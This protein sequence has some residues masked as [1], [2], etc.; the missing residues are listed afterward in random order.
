MN[1]PTAA[2]PRLPRQVFFIIGNEACERFSFYGMRNVLTTFLAGYLLLALPAAEREPAAKEVFHVFVMGVYFFPLLGGWLSDTFWGKYR[3][4]LWISLIYCAGQ[5]LLA[6]FDRDRIGFYSGLFL[7][8]VGSGGIKPCVAS[9][10]GDQFDETNKPLARVAFDAFYWVINF[11]SFFASL[12]IP[13]VLK[14]WGPA[15][16]FGI[17]GVLMALATLVLWLGRRRYVDVPP[18]PADPHSFARIARTALLARSPAGKRPGVVLLAIAV[19]L[20]FAGLAT[21]P[22]LGVVAGV[23]LAL[24]AFAV[25][26]GVGLGRQLEAARGHHPDEDVDGVRAVLRVLVVFALVTPFWSLFDQKASTWV[27]Q[28]GAMTLPGWRWLSSAAQ[29]QAINPALVMLLIPFNNVVAYPLL[30]RA[31]V[32]PTPLR[33]M[34]F[35]M[36]SAGLAWIAVALLQLRLDGGARVSILWQFL[37]YVLL[38]LGEVLVSATGL[39][40]AYSQAPAKMKGVLMSFWSLAVTVG[41]LWVIVVNALVKNAP[42]TRAIERTGIGVT[43]FQMFFFAAFAFASAAAFGAYSRRYRMVDYYRTA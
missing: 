6:V 43:A 20:A 17:P 18:A 25:P 24:V 40:F 7:I 37:P 34:T 3:T 35:G 1:A 19:A 28:A 29:M 39:E 4:I 14:K 32:E 10:V 26:F 41:N 5:A 23:C 21:I 30:R 16:A 36:A 2:E 15:F 27:L 38:T 11:G 33:R 22:W 31:G 13:L 42:V 12:L 9:F 8:A